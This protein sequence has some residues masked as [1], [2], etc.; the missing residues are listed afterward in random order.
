M[1]IQPLPK[2]T[3]ADLY[4]GRKILFD[5][6]PGRFKSGSLPWFMTVYEAKGII[7]DDIYG[8]ASPCHNQAGCIDVVCMV[9]GPYG[10]S[11]A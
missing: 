5:L 2:S 7:F 11:A 10:D 1:V 8:R 9:D 6:G 3:I 4:P